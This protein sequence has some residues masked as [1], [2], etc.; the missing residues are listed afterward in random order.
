MKK[1]D[2]LKL[3]IDAWA[4]SVADYV[5][6][7]MDSVSVGRRKSLLIVIFVVALIFL[8]GQTV[9]AFMKLHNNI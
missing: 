7:K 3:R 9:V 4:Q 5:K 1:M 6:G 2:L 8:I